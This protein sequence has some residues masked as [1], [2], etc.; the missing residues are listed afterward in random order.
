[1][2]IENRQALSDLE[3]AKTQLERLCASDPHVDLDFFEV[4]PERP[5]VKVRDVLPSLLDTTPEAVSH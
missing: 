3:R 2:N 5:D 4:T 1:M